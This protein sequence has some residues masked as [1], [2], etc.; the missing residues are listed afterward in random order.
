MGVSLGLVVCAVL[1]V[2]LCVGIP[3]SST[4]MYLLS[5]SVLGVGNT[6]ERVAQVCSPGAPSL[7]EKTDLSPMTTQT[8]QGWD[9]GGPGREVRAGIGEVQ[10]E[11]SGLGLGR[12]RQKDQGWGGGQRQRG[13]GWDGGT[14]TEGLGLG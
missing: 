1:Y 13:Q 9:G 7:L 6:V 11:G 2:P 14:K 3:V 4:N 8:G 10:T 5:S 12:P